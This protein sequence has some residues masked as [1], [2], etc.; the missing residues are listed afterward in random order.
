MTRKR[1]KKDR[2]KKSNGRWKKSKKSASGGRTSP[3]PQIQSQSEDTVAASS[4]Q[5]DLQHVE[6]CTSIPLP[7]T[8][9][10]DAQTQ[11]RCNVIHKN[12]QTEA[13]SLRSCHTQTESDP[14]CE[15]T[16]QGLG[17]TENDSPTTNE[18]KAADDLMA[19]PPDPGEDKKKGTTTPSKSDAVMKEEDIK[20]KNGEQTGKDSLDVSRSTETNP[21]STETKP[22]SHAEATSS[23][24]SKDKKN[25]TAAVQ[26]GKTH[27]SAAQR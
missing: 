26:E 13:I 11:T 17:N 27:D 9:K 21:M 24:D 8:G 7:A 14:R 2:K 10:A 1:T 16:I 5:S 3:P 20:N 18:E 12:I 23:K 22:K 25:Q 4:N 6:E 19:T 15:A